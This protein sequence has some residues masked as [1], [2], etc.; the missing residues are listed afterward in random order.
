MLEEQ[1]LQPTKDAGARMGTELLTPWELLEGPPL[2]QP[3]H[4]DALALISR[5][6]LLEALDCVPPG[7]CADPDRLRQLACAAAQA[8]VDLQVE[9]IPTDPFCAIALQRLI[10]HVAGERGADDL[11]GASFLA[12]SSA[13]SGG[14]RAAEAVLAACA[15][16]PARALRGAVEALV[17]LMDT[18][19]SAH[20]RVL[21]GLR[22]GLVSMVNDLR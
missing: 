4:E 5:G 14:G 22:A 1:P 19:G 12:R 20:S 17:G 9:E 13:A 15:H 3:W 18:P 16:D 8:A 7:R 6:R 2:P 21:D 11:D 10:E